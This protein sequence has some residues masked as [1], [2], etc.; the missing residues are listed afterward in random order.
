MTEESGMTA[1]PLAGKTAIV[2]GA[3]SGI[4]AIRNRAT[5]M[6]RTLS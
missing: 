6:N 5:F 2:T 3:G 1:L 4:G